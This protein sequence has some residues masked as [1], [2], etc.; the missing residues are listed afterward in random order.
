MKF[1]WHLTVVRFVMAG[2]SYYQISKPQ[3]AIP[4]CYRR[5]LIYAVR[6][7]EF[8][9]ERVCQKTSRGVYK[10][11][12]YESTR[13]F[14][15]FGI[16]FDIRLLFCF[17]EVIKY[18]FFFLLRWI[19]YYLRGVKYFDGINDNSRGIYIYKIFEI[20]YRKLVNGIIKE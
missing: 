7:T 14:V 5:W 8:A 16:F 18:F 13:Y 10:S 3:N 2:I 9:V 19:N 17:V 12:L 15:L 11:I 6:V 4:R 20:E 1:D